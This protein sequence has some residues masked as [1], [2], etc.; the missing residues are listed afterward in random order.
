VVF[1]VK[2]GIVPEVLKP[3]MIRVHGNELFVVEGAHIF[4]FSIKDLSLKKKFGKAGE[5]PGELRI[6]PNFT[7]GV[8]PHSDYIFAE[9]IDKVVF[10]SKEGKLIR[11]IRKF[12]RSAKVLPVGKNFVGKTRVVD[13]DNNVT[14]VLCIFDENMGKKKELF[15]Q[16]FPQRGIN[17]DAIPDSL[18][19]WVDDDKIFVEES[20]KGFVIE[21][22]DSEGNK[23]YQIAKKYN[24]VKVTEKDKEETFNRMKEDPLVKL[25]GWENIK[26]IIKFHFPDTFPAVRDVLVTGKKIYVRTFNKK[27]GKDE[28]VVMDLKGNI[29]KKMYQQIGSES[30]IMVSMLGLG[31]KFYSI[32]N[33]KFY[34]LTEDEG[35]EEWE[36]HVTNIK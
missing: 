12:A 5:G 23:L 13:K 20:P 8:T 7:V 11:E 9:S 33:N 32:E 1:A 3:E 4:I 22:F 28:F 19:F 14:S 17:L 16:R 35:E 31:P 25:Q 30:Q 26:R 10:Y 18:N 36:L 29:L 27:D 34:Y 24:K 15:S 2:I 21:V 6:V